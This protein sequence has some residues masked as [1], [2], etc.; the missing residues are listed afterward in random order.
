MKYEIDYPDDE[1]MENG[2]PII[3]F[4]WRN[5]EQTICRKRQEV[6]ALKFGDDGV[7]KY[8]L[9]AT[10]YPIYDE[11]THEYLG[12]MSFGYFNKLKN[13]SKDL[14]K[15]PVGFKNAKNCINC[16][17]EWDEICRKNNCYIGVSKDTVCDEW[18]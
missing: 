10:T 18:E 5:G 2:N 1:E 16:I 17:Y 14:V 8:Y 4:D 13:Y 6:I 3:L 12:Y 15:Y 9:T 11:L 7:Y